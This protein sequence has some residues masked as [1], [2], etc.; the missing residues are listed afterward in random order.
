MN[1]KRY[2]TLFTIALVVVLGL[3]AFQFNRLHNASAQLTKAQASQIQ[4]YRLASE[5]WQSID[6]QTRLAVNYAV[7]G[8]AKFEREYNAVIDIRNGKLERPVNYHHV[9][10]DLVSGGQPAR[11]GSGVTKSLLDLMREAGF[12]KEEFA[13]LEQVESSA[14]DLVRLEN[15]AIYAV[16]GRY[17]DA[18][19]TFGRLGKPDRDFA[20]RLLNGTEYLQAKAQTMLPLE[21]FFHHMEERT[22]GEIEAAESAQRQAQT[23]FISLF[24]AALIL[25]GL[26]SFLMLAQSKRDLERTESEKKRTEREN[27]QLNDSVINILQAV[28][29]LSQRDLTVRAPVTEDVIGT[30]SDSIN[31]LA[32]ETARVLMGVTDIAGHV[33][34]ASGNVKSRA[35]QVTRTAEEERTNVNQMM[36]SLFEATQTM[37]QVAALAEQSNISAGE[38]TEVTHNALGTVTDTVRDMESIRETIAE[39]EKRIKR[40]GERSQEISGIVN[41]INTIAERTHVLALNASMQA[42]VA[43]EAGR[44]FAVVAEEVQR[45]AESSRNATE[46]IATLVNNIQVETNETINTVNKTIEQV[47]AGSEQAQKAGEQ[48]RRTQ[49][50]TAQLVEQVRHIAG[51]SEQQKAMS[52]QLL[53]AV[54]KI[55]SSTEN[56]AEQ[57]QAQNR[58]TDSL[59]DTARQLVDSVSVF[60]LPQAA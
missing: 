49:E 47:V 41:L 19:N 42:A 3:L 34:Q 10:W 48:M 22:K 33:A 16:K 35:E 15:Q 40:L 54:Q 55:G 58:E 24:L 12:S 7:T 53:E 27:E 9:Y 51:A 31:A 30:I 23:L 14:R 46:Q 18:S 25:I 50:I 56:T 26:V 8:D 11:E 37:N 17:L 43:G 29:Q 2:I 59:L 20:I 32:E 57:I 5:L 36:E 28:N 39:T 21:D 52:A 1:L 6:D 45:L 44:G 60:K 4:S 38:A 13:A